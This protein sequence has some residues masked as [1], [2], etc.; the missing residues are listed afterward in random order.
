MV[1]FVGL[2]ILHGLG[3]DLDRRN[4]LKDIRYY[5]KKA[6]FSRLKIIFIYLLVFHPIGD[7][8]HL[9]DLYLLDDHS[10]DQVYALDDLLLLDLEV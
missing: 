4:L 7:F 6:N 9:D 2:Q 10:F 8:H 1:V 5:V 3:H